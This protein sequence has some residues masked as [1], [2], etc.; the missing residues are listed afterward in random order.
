MKET[1]EMTLCVVPFIVTALMVY[2]FMA[3]VGAS[4]DPFMWSRDDRIF[5][6]ICSGLYGWALFMRIN[7]ARK[8]EV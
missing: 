7:H 3:I 4:F 2:P 1:K 6:G 5:Y 8:E